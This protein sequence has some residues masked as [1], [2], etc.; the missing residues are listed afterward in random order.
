L[1]IP[2]CLSS[3][4]LLTE[5]CASTTTLVR[6][7]IMDSQRPATFSLMK[8][9]KNQQILTLQKPKNLTLN[10]RHSLLMYMNNVL[11]K[12]FSPLC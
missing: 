7:L 1:K 2:S 8:Q 5:F 10:N 6:T 9:L 12:T 11:K 4:S 3:R